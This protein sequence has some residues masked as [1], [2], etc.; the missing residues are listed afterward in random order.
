M[1]PG[2]FSVSEFHVFQVR[3][4]RV[5]RVLAVVHVVL[6]VDD[7]GVFKFGGEVMLLRARSRSAVPLDRDLGQTLTLVIFTGL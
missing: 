5:R 1:G 4:V 7:D 2:D 6:D 3:E